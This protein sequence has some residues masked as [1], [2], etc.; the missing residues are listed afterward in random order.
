LG[1]GNRDG[2]ADT[3]A[4]T[5]HNGNFLGKGKWFWHSVASSLNVRNQ[6]LGNAE[7]I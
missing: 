1:K 3:F 7:L 4:G 2:L 5:G 6:R